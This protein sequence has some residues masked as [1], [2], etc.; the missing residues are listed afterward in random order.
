MTISLFLALSVA[1]I[2]LAKKCTKFLLV[3]ALILHMHTPSTASCNCRQS[4]PTMC[5]LVLFYFV[6]HAI[7]SMPILFIDIFKGVNAKAIGF[8]ADN[9]DGAYIQVHYSPL[10]YVLLVRGN[11][12]LKIFCVGCVL[13]I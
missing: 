8:Y 9:F 6:F 11:S 1:F 13:A 10:H 5:F 3:H 4:Y 12:K 2:P 7:I